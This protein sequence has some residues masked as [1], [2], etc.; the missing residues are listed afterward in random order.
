MDVCIF[1]KNK[2]YGLSIVIQ[3]GSNVTTLKNLGLHPKQLVKELF[4]VCL[5]DKWNKE[6]SIMISVNVYLLCIKS[7]QIRS[8]STASFKFQLNALIVSS[9]L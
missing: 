1:C 7:G 3:T 4:H 9:Q 2:K 6:Q 5:K 8:L